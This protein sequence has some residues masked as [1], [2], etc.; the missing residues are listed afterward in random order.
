MKGTII[1]VILLI[2]MGLVLGFFY[3]QLHPSLGESRTVG[4]IQFTVHNYAINKSFFGHYPAPGAKYLVIFVE[5][6]NVG[7]T[8]RYPPSGYWD[9]VLKYKGESIRRDEGIEWRYMYWSDKYPRSPGKIYPDVKIVGW[10]CYEVP[11][12]IDINDAYILVDFPFPHF[13]RKWSLHNEFDSH[14]LDTDGDRVIDCM[15]IYYGTDPNKNDTDNDGLEDRT[16]LFNL[17]TD[18]LNSDSDGDGLLDGDEFYPL[19]T[20]PDNWDTDGDGL[21][22]GDEVNTFLTSPLRKDTDSDGLTDY[23][24]IYTYGTDPNDPDSDGGAE[25]KIYKHVIKEGF[26]M[27]NSKA[28]INGNIVK[29]G[30]KTSESE[31][32]LELRCG[33]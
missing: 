2:S 30:N 29:N 9:I 6:K 31:L 11:E 28:Q 18:P 3:Q 19:C 10:L 14:T 13:N 4:G 27:G 25:S 20:E 12:K 24:E 7:E 17:G 22:D 21:S 32:R 8:A 5:A 33:L 26:R 23:E 1:A 15:E 16:E